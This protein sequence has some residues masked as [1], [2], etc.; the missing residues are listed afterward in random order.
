MTSNYVSSDLDYIGSM[1]AL[2]TFQG[3]PKRILVVAGGKPYGSKLMLSLFGWYG[4]H[5]VMIQSL[6]N[7]SHRHLCLLSQFWLTTCL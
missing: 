1:S 4:G 2:T 3:S 6:G 7:L 5:R